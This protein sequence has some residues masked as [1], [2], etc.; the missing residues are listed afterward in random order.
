MP[1]ALVPKMN[2]V[3]GYRLDF[4]SAL[5]FIDGSPMV[6]YGDGASDTKVA[7]IPITLFTDRGQEPIEAAIAPMYVLNAA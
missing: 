7:G 6:V 5:Q 1:M 4:L 3:N 2:N